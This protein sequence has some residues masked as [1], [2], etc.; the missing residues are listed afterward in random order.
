MGASF[1]PWR[2]VTEQ[3]GGAVMKVR[4]LMR[5]DVRTCSRDETL[6]DVARAMWDM[7]V[8]CLPVVDQLGRPVAMITD[9]DICMA[10][11][12]QGVPLANMPVAS[13][14]SRGIVTCMPDTSVHALEALMQHYQ[15]RRLPVVN[16][17]GVLVGIVGLADLA[18][19]E[20]MVTALPIVGAGILKTLGRITERRWQGP[21]A[22]E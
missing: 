17:D 2:D 9:R 12:M 14:M 18:R 15:V 19:P 1:A 11:C 3:K 7:D 16:E 13:A 5:H 20:R 21:L 22:A 4:D 10:A 6:A 8:G